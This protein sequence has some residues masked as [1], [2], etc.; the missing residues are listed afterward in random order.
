MV[1][2]VA[3]GVAVPTGSATVPGGKTGLSPPN[4]W[5][6][7]GVTGVVL[8]ELPGLAGTT[9]LPA[10]GTGGVEGTVRPR[11]PFGDRPGP[12]LLYP[13]TVAVEPVVAGVTGPI[14]GLMNPAFGATPGPL[15]LYPPVVVGVV[16]VGVV[17]VVLLAGVIVAPG[18]GVMGEG[19][20]GAAVVGTGVVG[21]AG[22]APA[23]AVVV[24]R[25]AKAQSPVPKASRL[26]RIR[27]MHKRFMLTPPRPLVGPPL[28]N[29]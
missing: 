11:P 8:M 3:A 18:T 25:W 17:P 12:L 27:L 9:A 22:R 10:P 4:S 6:N 29:R 5:L 26:P 19:V 23:G 1:V 2:A 21:A 24:V 20:M 16:V 14:L 13:G 15:L 7:V 28:S